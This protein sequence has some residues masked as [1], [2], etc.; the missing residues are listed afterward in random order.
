[1]IR[2]APT[3][4]GAIWA[5]ADRAFK[6]DSN[7][8]AV[9]DQIYELI[10]PYR[11]FERSKGHSKM[12]KV[13]DSTAVRSAFRFAGRLQLDIIP[14]FQ[15]WF[16]LSP[17]PAAEAQLS[18]KDL[19]ELREKLQRTQ[20]Q[21]FAALDISSF[22]TTGNEMCQDLVAGQ[23]AMLISEGDDDDPL[24]FE[25]VPSDQIAITDGPGGRVNGVH[26]KKKMTYREVV[27][28][29][30]DATYPKVI[31][32]AL[33]K[34][35]DTERD[36]ALQGEIEVLQASLWQKPDRRWVLSVIAP[37][38]KGHVLIH[39]N[40]T[41]SAPWITPRFFKVPGE[42]R[43]RGPAWL[44]LPD[45]RVANKTVELTLR[46]AALAILGLWTR[47]PDFSGMSALNMGQIKPGSTIPVNRNAGGIAGPSLAALDIPRN[48]D[49]SNLLL[50]DYRDRIRETLFDRAIPRSDGTPRSAS[51]I[52]ESIRLYSEDLASAY[53][54]LVKEIVLPTV[55]RV[56]EILHNKGLLSDKYEIDQ[57]FIQVR[58]KSALASAQ[59]LMQ[60]RV[61]T[62]W[63]EIMGALMPSEIVL[64]SAKLEDIG[65]EIGRLLGVPE[66]LMRDA[67]E[68][69]ELQKLVA[70]IMA[71][72]EIAKQTA[73]AEQAA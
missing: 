29:W 56:L 40:K 1:M 7:Y 25:A 26:Y 59:N 27:D 35:N 17:G 28:T 67:K 65:W 58:V 54:R 46:A 37:D 45:V 15:E 6:A 64:M 63:L 19:K 42:S 22:H 51:E 61:L 48:F 2:T 24:L 20:K 12:D 18:E 10:L 16:Q 69:G 55:Q 70:Q 3:Q 68:K 9:L 32:D 43:G 13:F 49:V 21:V 11:H 72:Q 38:D 8:D 52:I 39:E 50:A 60:V 71:N 31:R 47:T 36:A 4:P 66:N 14:P 62:Q 73:A 53:G 34:T 57:L 5:H 23:G 41:R 33:A 44:A 30:P